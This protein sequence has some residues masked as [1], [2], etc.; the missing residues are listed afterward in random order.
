MDW[1][2]ILDQ[3]FD[4]CLIPLLGLATSILIVYVKAKIA[5]GKEKTNT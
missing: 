5:E 2:N 1:L 4:V 3:V